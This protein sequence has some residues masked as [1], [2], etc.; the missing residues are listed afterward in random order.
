MKKKALYFFIISITVV[1]LI[2]LNSKGKRYTGI[3][4]NVFD[5]KISNFQKI[6]DLFERDQNYKE[7]IKKINDNEIN[8]KKKNNK[9][10]QMGLSKY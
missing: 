6:N 10:K 3:N 7:L 2:F 5:E 8:E 9:H 1:L 4:Y